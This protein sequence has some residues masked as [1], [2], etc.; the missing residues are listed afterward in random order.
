MFLHG[1]IYSSDFLFDA[2]INYLCTEKARPK[3]VRQTENG[4]VKFYNR[5]NYDSTPLN[6]FTEIKLFE[7]SPNEYSQSRNNFIFVQPNLFLFQFILDLFRENPEH[8]QCIRYIVNKSIVSRNDVL[9]F[10]S[11]IRNEIGITTINER[12]ILDIFKLLREEDFISFSELKKLIQH[13][14]DLDEESVLK[15]LKTLIF[16][17]FFVFSDAPNLLTSKNKCLVFIEFLNSQMREERNI[18][19]TE[20]IVILNDLNRFIESYTLDSNLMLINN[21]LKRIYSLFSTYFERL[22]EEIKISSLYFPFKK[23]NIV[24][25]D[26][27]DLEPGQLQIK[28]FDVMLQDIQGLIDCF[29]F[30]SEFTLI[31]GLMKEFFQKTYTN[32]SNVDLIKFYLDFFSDLE[33]DSERLKIMKNQRL[34]EFEKFEL[35]LRKVLE[36]YIEQVGVNPEDSFISL[37]EINFL[38]RNF[39]NLRNSHSLYFNIIDNGTISINSISDGYGRAESRFIQYFDQK[40]QDLLCELNRGNHNNHKVFELSDYNFFN[41]NL[42]NNLAPYEIDYQLNHYYSNTTK[43]INPN[44]IFVNLENDELILIDSEGNKLYPINVNLQNEEQRSQFFQFLNSFNS[45][46][47]LYLNILYKIVDEIFIKRQLNA[48]IQ[49]IPGVKISEHVIYSFEHWMIKERY[50][51][52]VPSHLNIHTRQML[53]IEFLRTRNIPITCFIQFDLGRDY[54]KPEFFDL[55]LL[56]YFNG[57]EKQVNDLFFIVHPINCASN[58]SFISTWYNRP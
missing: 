6:T 50:S 4:L 5:A 53:L 38:K 29:Y 16:N 40:Y 8:F 43:K 24:Y 47:S 12:F 32:E 58:A 33:D 18:Y 37:K 31:Q 1:V 57:F 7:Y 9:R 55:N 22:S 21:E 51:Q 49:Y 17:G 20:L 35:G 14:F 13:Q 15:L 44:N 26:L 27:V 45:S 42:H 52:I 3:K 41:A 36:D 46:P 48:K 30:P 25:V 28:D 23:Y 10:F 2:T 54:S 56:V 39:S 34:I 11:P 19:F